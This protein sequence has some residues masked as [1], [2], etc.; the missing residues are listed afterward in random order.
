[1]REYFDFQYILF[2]GRAWERAEGSNPRSGF[3]LLEYEIY[4][5]YLGAGRALAGPDSCTFGF[6][7]AVSFHWEV[8]YMSWAADSKSPASRTMV[9]AWRRERKFSY[10]FQM[11]NWSKIIR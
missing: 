4:N 9:S 6:D 5:K 7:V 1:V 8:S 11:S 2:C 3:G 10:S